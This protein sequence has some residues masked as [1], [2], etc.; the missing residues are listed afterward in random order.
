MP[1]DPVVQG[2][3][4]TGGSTLL[5][6][7]LSGSSAGSANRDRKMQK[8]FAKKGIRWRVKD[9][10]AAG[11]HPLAALG[12]SIASP[13]PTSTGGQKSDY[14]IAA[15]GQEIGRA[16]A[17]RQTQYQKDMQT[18]ILAKEIELGEGYKIDNAIKQKRLDALNN[19]QSGPPQADFFDTKLNPNS[20][21]GSGNVNESP[22]GIE[23]VAKQIT[24]KKSP[25]TTAGQAAGQDDFNYKGYNLRMLNEK[26]AESAE[27]DIVNKGRIIAIQA[28]EMKNILSAHMATRDLGVLKRFG[29]H[30]SKLQFAESKQKAQR[31]IA[32]LRLQRAKLPKYRYSIW[33]MDPVLGW[34]S[35]PATREN[36]KRFFTTKNNPTPY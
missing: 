20:I 11:L 6:S 35:V 12:A 13:S 1:L 32:R 31:T 10:Q 7:A 22:Q 14:G 26:A 30:S 17:S 2:A 24:A 25:S 18:A 33:Q 16:L 8:D 27:N 21:F 9:A 36:R 23:T 4:V 34:K 19:I 3:L 15:A 29:L 5:G 28:K